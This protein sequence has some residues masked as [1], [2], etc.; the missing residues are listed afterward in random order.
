VV[1]T[2]HDVRGGPVPG[3]SGLFARPVPGTISFRDVLQKLQPTRPPVA[4][5]GPGR[6][7][8]APR[9]L[10]P[11]HS[12]PTGLRTTAPAPHAKAALAAAIRTAAGSASVEPAL[13]VAVAR[14]ESNLDP[15][16]R[17]IDGKS[18]GTFQM[19]A[20]TAAEM[21][22]KI[23]AGT[24]ARPPGSDDVALGVGYL[25]Y[26]DGVFTRRAQLARGLATVPVADT[27]ERK[28]FA[29]AAFNAGEGRVA[30]AQALAAAH[31]GD[32]TRFADVR[33]YLPDVTRTY[34]ARVTAYAAAER[35]A[36]A[37]A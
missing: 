26:L 1:P 3:V 24:I 13:S 6:V 20:A 14:A 19:T 36:D 18:V 29:V 30:R 7:L 17:S 27:G 32:P 8:P 2:I 37:T 4:R 31:G 33:P 23:A 35:T 28:L 21:R 12:A 16:A 15:R 25:R 5:L 34:V 10:R 22:R 11:G 9:P